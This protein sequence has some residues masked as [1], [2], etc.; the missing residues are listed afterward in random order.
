VQSPAVVQLRAL[1]RFFPG[2]KQFLSR[3]FR[4]DQSQ[5]PWCFQSTPI[6]SPMLFSSFSASSTLDLVPLLTRLVEWPSYVSKQPSPCPLPFH[7]RAEKED[8]LP[9]TSV[10]FYSECSCCTVDIVPTCA[11]FGAGCY[12]CNSG[13]VYE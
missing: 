3:D 7:W 1:P 8:M 13:N 6:S 11:A 10:G 4:S 9:S 5:F 2:I 12:S